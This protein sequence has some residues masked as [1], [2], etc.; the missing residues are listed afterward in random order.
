M[1][2]SRVLLFIYFVYR[3]VCVCVNPE[4]L[5]YPSSSRLFLVPSYTGTS[6]RPRRHRRTNL[7]FECP[8]FFS[9]SAKIRK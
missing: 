5:I 2:H 7:Y 3:G 8:V 6:Q 1:L 9:V 4:P